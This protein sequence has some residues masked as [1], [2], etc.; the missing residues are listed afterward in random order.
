MIKSIG[1]TDQDII[2]DI[3]KLY[4]IEKIDLDPCYSKGSFYKDKLVK[5]P[6]FRSDILPQFDFVEKHDVRNLPFPDN[7]IKS[8]IFDPPFL[9]TTGKSLEKNDDSNKLNK[10]FTVFPNEN[11][12]FKFYVE[13][14]KELHRVLNNDGILIFKCQ[15]KVSSG[16]QYLSHVFII[17]EAEK[18]GFY[19]EDFFILLAKNRIVADWQL[20]TQKHA[21][22][23]HCYYLVLRKCNKK[24][25]YIK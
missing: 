13:S 11:E 12:L 21:R 15:D 19:V 8:V 5:E 1:Y 6:T 14:L 17:N 9:A 22:K 7:F 24:I 2:F 20:K 18:A 3:C 10:R 4:S 23:F 16:K 25:V